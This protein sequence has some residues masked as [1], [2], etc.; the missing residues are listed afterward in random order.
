M[1]VTSPTKVFSVFGIAFFALTAC[2][3]INVY[4]PEAAATRAADSVVCEVLGNCDDNPDMTN[5]NDSSSLDALPASARLV[6]AGSG[7]GY[8]MLGKVLNTLVPAAQAQADIDVNSAGS[9]DLRQSM[10]A[11]QQ[12]LKPF[13]DS[14]AVGFTNNGLVD[15]RDLGLV[16]LPQRAMLRSLVSAE[17]NDRREL[18]AEIARVNGHPEWEDKIQA[19]FAER[20]IARASSGWYYQNASGNWV[21]K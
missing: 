16:S 11:R 6:A 4:F 15:V 9:R 1:N 18:Y 3:T 10:E 2:V 21:Q 14:G 7:I 12:K 8:S 13:L 5:K 19:A 20:W 17:N